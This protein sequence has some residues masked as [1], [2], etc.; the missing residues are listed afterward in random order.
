MSNIR[1]TES[2]ENTEFDLERDGVENT[3]PDDRKLGRLQRS[4]VAPVILKGKTTE[5]GK[6]MFRLSAYMWIAILD[7]L[8]DRKIAINTFKNRGHADGEKRIGRTRDF[9]LGSMVHNRMQDIDD[10]VNLVHELAG[11]CDRDASGEIGVTPYYEQSFLYVLSSLIE[12]MRDYYERELRIRRESEEGRRLAKDLCDFWYGIAHR[13]GL[14]RR[15]EGVEGHE[16]FVAT[17]ESRIIPE[18]EG[19]A[20]TQEKIHGMAERFLPMVAKISNT[21]QA[22]FVELLQSVRPTLARLLALDG[23]EYS[24]QRPRTRSL[25][26]ETLRY[27]AGSLS[28]KIRLLLSGPTE[29]EKTLAILRQAAIRPHAYPAIRAVYHLSRLRP[30]IHLA[31]ERLHLQKGEALIEEGC[32][33]DNLYI[34]LSTSAPL[35]IVVKKEK[36]AEIGPGKPRILGEMGMF[37]GITQ[38]SVLAREDADLEVIRI[39]REQFTELLKFPEGTWLKRTLIPQMQSRLK[40]NER[41]L[42]QAGEDALLTQIS[43]E[44]EAIAADPARERAELSERI[45]AL[46]GTTLSYLQRENISAQTIEKLVAKLWDLGLLKETLNGGGG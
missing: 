31:R 4:I 40:D 21:S 41:T 34:V 16:A 35:D 25:A 6:R 15:P 17:H 2:S 12:R 19:D 32:S 13:V 30:D 44:A 22:E 5:I 29:Q 38:A 27:F 18:M 7:D 23:K 11:V 45:D 24:S 9:F 14:H 42:Q 36:V 28:N 20:S 3:L 43:K 8:L 10:F 39:P 26:A 33:P 46:M 37:K 1:T